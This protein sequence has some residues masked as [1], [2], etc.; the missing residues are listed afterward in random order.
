VRPSAP[1]SVSA[2]TEAGTSKGPLLAKKKAGREAR[3]EARGRKR[4]LPHP[5]NSE[6]SLTHLWLLAS[7]ELLERRHVVDGGRPEFGT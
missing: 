4:T 7:S 6:V 1:L 3:P 5:E 2:A